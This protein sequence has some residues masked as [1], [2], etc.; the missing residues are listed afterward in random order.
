MTIS[1]NASNDTEPKLYTIQKTAARL[2]G[3]D[4]TPTDLNRIY[5]MVAKRELVCQKVGGRKFIPV[6]QIE[7]L[8]QGN[9]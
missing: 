8:E 2:F 6:W 1:L 9:E 4:Y 3:S 7:K 5:R